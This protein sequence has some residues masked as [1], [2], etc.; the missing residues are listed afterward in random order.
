MFAANDFEAILSNVKDKIV[1]IV[2]MLEKNFG[3]NAIDKMD[4]SDHYSRR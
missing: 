3:T 1:D 4:S 2:M